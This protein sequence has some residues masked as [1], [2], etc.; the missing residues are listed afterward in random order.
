MFKELEQRNAF[1]DNSIIN[2]KLSFESKVTRKF[3]EKE[4]QYPIKKAG[5][6]PFHIIWEKIYIPPHNVPQKQ[7]TSP[8][9]FS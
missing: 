4:F 6:L 8:D 2:A 5:L 3:Y 9:N 1:G 7:I